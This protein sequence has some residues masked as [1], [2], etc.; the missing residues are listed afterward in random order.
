MS[1]GDVRGTMEIDRTSLFPLC[2]SFKMSLN[3]VV[4]EL[5]SL[6]TEIGTECDI[7]LLS[8]EFLQQQHEILFLHY[9]FQ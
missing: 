3:N 4:S 9:F 1:D 8:M 2:I 5:V 7:V 6:V